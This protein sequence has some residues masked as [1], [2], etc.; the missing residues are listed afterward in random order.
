MSKEDEKGM[1]TKVFQVVD[2]CR[3]DVQVELV[4]VSDTPMLKLS[5]FERVIYILAGL[6]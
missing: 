4:H 2:W 6:M 3:N 5:C 1:H